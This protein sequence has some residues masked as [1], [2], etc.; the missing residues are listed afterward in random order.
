M[1][2][3]IAIALIVIALAPLRSAWQATDYRI[4]GGI[5]RVASPR[6]KAALEFH[7]SKIRPRVDEFGFWH[8]Y[9]DGKR[10]RLYSK[11]FMKKWREK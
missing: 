11:A 5:A 7:G 6:F 9:R 3:S 8:F 10:C 4:E 2:L 1:K